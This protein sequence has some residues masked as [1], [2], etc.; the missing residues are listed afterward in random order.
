MNAIVEAKV[1]DYLRNWFRVDAYDVGTVLECMRGQAQAGGNDLD[2]PFRFAGL[3]AGPEA[4]VASGIVDRALLGGGCETSDYAI[5][6]QLRDW[7]LRNRR[8]GQF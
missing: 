1:G 6:M 8:K 7:I 4:R 5:R 3:G 2:E